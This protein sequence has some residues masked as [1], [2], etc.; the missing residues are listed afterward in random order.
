MRENLISNQNEMRKIKNKKTI[1]VDEVIHTSL[2]TRASKE[3]KQIR[4][5]VEEILKKALEV[6][7]DE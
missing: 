7:G 1:N 4:E 6:E 3:R 2:K 5:L